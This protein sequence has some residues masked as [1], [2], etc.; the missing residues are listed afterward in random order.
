MIPCRIL[1]ADD[2]AVIRTGIRYLLA[3]HFDVHEVGEADSCASLLSALGAAP[4]THV[5]LDLQMGDCNSMDMIEQL[6]EHFPHVSVLVYK[7]SP[8]AIFGKRVMQMGVNGFLSK[9]AD[10]EEVI[11]ALQHFLEGRQYVSEELKHV[12]MKDSGRPENPFADLSERET[13]VLRFLLQG[14]RVK[15]ISNQLDLKMSTVATYKVRIFEKL[16]V[17]NVMDLQRL[18]NVYNFV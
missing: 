10:E 1:L 9:Q 6:M 7:M 8:E 5:V 17:D 2:H 13:S 16:N 4:C 14:H 11:R 18:A 3:R 15:E 12:L